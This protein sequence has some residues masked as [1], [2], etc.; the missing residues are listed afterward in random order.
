MIA[1]IECI[2]GLSIAQIGLLLDIAGFVLIFIFGGFQF[3][4]SS[5]I[6]DDYDWYVLPTRILASLMVVVGFAFQ[7]IGEWH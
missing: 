7:F 6:A 5:Y 3:G 2:I 1:E 4:V